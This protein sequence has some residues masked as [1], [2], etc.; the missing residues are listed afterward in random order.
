MRIKL[1]N[2]AQYHLRTLADP[3]LLPLENLWQV[4]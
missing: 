4:I 1:L 2:L 3:R